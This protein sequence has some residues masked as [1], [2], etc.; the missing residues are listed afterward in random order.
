MVE[1]CQWC[2]VLELPLS[3]VS[4]EEANKGSSSSSQLDMLSANSR[5]PGAQ[6]AAEK[7]KTL[8]VYHRILFCIKNIKEYLSKKLV[9]WSWRRATKLIDVSRALCPACLTRADASCRVRV[10]TP[11]QSRRQSLLRSSDRGS[12]KRWT[13]SL[14]RTASL[15]WEPADLRKFEGKKHF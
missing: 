4:K 15:P 2:W 5:W 12:H 9:S 1:V 14:F 6:G 11:T 8:I 3:V 13:R 10:N 7:K